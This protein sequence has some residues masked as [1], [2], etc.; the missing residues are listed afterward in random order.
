MLAKDQMILCFYL[1][2]LV[3]ISVGDLLVYSGLKLCLLKV[4]T[5]LVI[6]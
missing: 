4:P 3:R 1:C 5:R 6:D 2:L